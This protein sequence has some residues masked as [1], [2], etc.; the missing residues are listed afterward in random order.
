M[1][2]KIGIL[3]SCLLL[4]FTLVG[5]SVQPEAIPEP[6]STPEGVYEIGQHVQIDL[7][8]LTIL[9]SGRVNAAVDK[10]HVVYGIYVRAYNHDT[11]EV[12]FDTTN[13][14]CYAGEGLCEVYET[15]IEHTIIAPQ[16]FVEGWIY[17]K[18]PAT[19][20]GLS[21]TYTYNEDGDY[22]VFIVSEG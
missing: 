14:S 10:A 17:Y 7:L 12:P 20:G 16:S 18:I 22:L 15:E 4:V 9:D 8:G 19:H 6:T 1:L 5:C 3:F 11:I 2:K 21:F 13:I